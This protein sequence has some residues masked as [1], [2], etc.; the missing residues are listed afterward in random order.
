MA[1][2]SQIAALPNGEFIFTGDKT[3]MHAKWNGAAFEYHL[4]D[5]TH[6]T[7]MKLAY[8]AGHVVYTTIGSPILNVWSLEKARRIH[9]LVGHW[10][11]INSLAVL[12]TGILAAA[13]HACTVIGWNVTTRERV[14]TCMQATPVLLVVAL[15]NG[16]F[17]TGARE[18]RVMV[19]TPEAKVQLILKTEPCSS[20][21]GVVDL[22]LVGEDK[23]ATVCYHEPKVD[24]WDFMTGVLLKQIDV[25]GEARAVCGLSNGHSVIASTLGGQH[26]VMVVDSVFEVKQLVHA[27]EEPSRLVPLTDG[28][29]AICT[30]TGCGSSLQVWE[31]TSALVS[32]DPHEEKQID[33]QA[34]QT[35]IHERLQMKPFHEVYSGSRGIVK[36]SNLDKDSGNKQA[37]RE[38][39]ILKSPWEQH[40]STIKR[41]NFDAVETVE[42]FCKCVQAYPLN[43]E[44]LLPFIPSGLFMEAF[45]QSLSTE[46]LKRLDIY[47]RGPRQRGLVHHRH[48]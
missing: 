11:A 43:T 40:T 45:M 32:P 18:N 46:Q 31:R 44:R 42:D 23:L 24:V 16:M 17:A 41:W 38:E 5:I 47:H 34:Q 37:L 14:F 7:I 13:D 4:L 27:R 30:K 28:K 35:G 6:L 21:F 22:A 26:Q 48:V 36:G 33:G 8:C 39:F 3:V 29:L 10:N 19:W 9:V 25:P 2:N 15:P 12:T 20:Q 1:L